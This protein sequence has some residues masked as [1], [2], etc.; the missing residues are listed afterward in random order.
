MWVL[1]WNL[2]YRILLSMD[3]VTSPSFSQSKF[4]MILCLWTMNLQRSHLYGSTY[5]IAELLDSSV[6]G[7][8]IATLQHSVNSF[9]AYMDDML[10]GR[11][12]RQL[13]VESEHTVQPFHQ[14]SFGGYDHHL[15]LRKS[16]LYYVY[17]V[18]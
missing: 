2:I 14:L 7:S 6:I 16:K 8:M 4:Q 15:L 13:S 11:N 18:F 10:T 5:H 1:L 12:S 9:D 3:S 17:L